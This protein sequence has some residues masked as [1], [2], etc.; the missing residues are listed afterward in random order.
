M[1]I[2]PPNL[3]IARMIA[4]FQPASKDH[5]DLHTFI[6]VA[7]KSTTMNRIIHSEIMREDTTWTYNDRGSVV[8]RG[9]QITSYDI[10]IKLPQ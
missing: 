2:W 9:D 4:F 6:G 10:S 7:L 8:T 5:H 1:V 3:K